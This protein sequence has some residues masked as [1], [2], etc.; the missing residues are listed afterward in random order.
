MARLSGWLLLLGLWLY[1]PA[2][3]AEISLE[4]F[5]G[6]AFPQI[7]PEARMLWLSPAAKQR[8]GTVL[9]H[10]L[11]GLRVKYWAAGARSAWVLDEIG[12]EE[13]ITIGVVIEQDRIASVQILAFRES[14]GGEVRYPAFTRQFERA[15]L[16]AQDRLSNNID[17]ITG[18]TLSVSAVTRISRLALVL[19]Q[20][21]GITQ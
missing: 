18:A 21:A 13:P 6:Q 7:K 3:R 4:R 5:L 8:A 12:K 9:G 10:E 1:S 11:P 17:G 16:Q 15:R 14:R 2:L 19:H 20:E